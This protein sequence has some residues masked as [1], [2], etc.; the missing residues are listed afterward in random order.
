LIIAIEIPGSNGTD[1]FLLDRKK[2]EDYI[3]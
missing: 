1:I 3:L 2:T